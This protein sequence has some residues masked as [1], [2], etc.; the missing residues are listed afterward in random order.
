MDKSFSFISN[1]STKK[2]HFHWKH[3]IKTDFSQSKGWA[4][5]K[6]L[7]PKLTAFIEQQ[8]LRVANCHSFSS[9]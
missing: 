2:R 9:N 5:G 7:T 8:N 4:G 6:Y 1:Q 3:P